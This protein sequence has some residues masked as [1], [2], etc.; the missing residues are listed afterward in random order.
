MVLCLWGCNALDKSDQPIE[1]QASERFGLQITR[2]TS[3]ARQPR[4]ERCHGQPALVV[5]PRGSVEVP[6]RRG[7]HTLSGEFAI[8]DLVGAA[9]VEFRVELLA[10]ATRVLLGQPAAVPE[11]QPRDSYPFL[12][13][14]WAEEDAPLLLQSVGE[15]PSVK[16]AWLGLHLDSVPYPVTRPEAVAAKKPKPQDDGLPDS[17][18]RPG[19][20]RP[21]ATLEVTPSGGYWL[22]D[23]GWN[24][25]ASSWGPIEIDQSNGAEY[26]GDGSP[27]TINGRVFGKGVGMHPPGRIVVDL[28]RRCRGFTAEVGVDDAVG[29]AGSV[30]F[31]VFADNE[32]LFK[33]KVLTGKDDPE[34][35]DVPLNGRG[36]LVLL[37]ENSDDGPENDWANWAEAQLFCDPP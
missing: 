33:S 3:E 25:S 5:P 7:F 29:D 37:V 2:V 22:T 1:Q 16:T 8:C 34:R 4:F 35:V 26:S 28:Y 32:P 30:Q 14:F 9:P 36:S 13:T 21:A 10:T 27:L 19:M 12:V 6:V 24:A 20:R 23:W 11:L 31:F 18:A 17:V 15:S